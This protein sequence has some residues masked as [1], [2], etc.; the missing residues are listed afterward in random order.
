[1]PHFLEVVLAGAFLVDFDAHF[2]AG[3]F[4]VVLAE[5]F[6]F[7]DAAGFLLEVAFFLMGVPLTGLASASHIAP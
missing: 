1:M 7:T 2:F 4:F 3:A 5:A 6:L